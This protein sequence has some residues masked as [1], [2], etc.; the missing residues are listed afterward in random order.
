MSWY[1]LL[2]RQGFEQYIK[3]QLI[4]KQKNLAFQEIFI[5]E[6][7]SGYVFIRSTTILPQQANH[8]LV[9][10]GTL[11]FLGTKKEGPQKF[12]TAQIR[13]LS[14]SNVE[15]KQTKSSLF[16]TGDHVIIKQGD[17]SD[18]DG[19]I[20]EIRKRIVKIKPLYFDKV[21]KSRVQDI[22]HI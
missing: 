3:E 8:F 19:V 14:V 20:V 6:E 15:L 4:S 16:K 21:V 11:K 9:F 1:I 5:S 2:V 13:K 10:E 12:T 17:L 7:L 22:E 18:I